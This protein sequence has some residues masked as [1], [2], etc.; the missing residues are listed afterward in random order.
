MHALEQPYLDLLRDVLDNGTVKSD[1]T[2]TGTISSF[3]RQ[4]RFDLSRGFPLL[5][6]K[7]MHTKSIIGELLW[8]LR[9]ETNVQSLQEDGIRIWNEWAD[10]TGELGPVYGKQ[11]RRWEGKNGVVVDQ[12]A[13]LVDDLKNNPNS[14]RMLVSAW[15]VAE[16][17]EAALPPC[18]MLF[19]CYVAN[20][21]LSCQLYQRSCDLF[22]GVPFNIA[23]YSLLTH[24]LALECGLEVGEFIW[25]GGDCH[26]YQ[27]HVAQVQLQL[28]RTPFAPPQLVI[29]RKA[30]DLYSYKIEDF[31]I[32]DYQCHERI[33]ASVAV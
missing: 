16:I 6:T 11:W 23:S 1:R 31:E 2:G 14:R 3:A 25:T 19:Q 12:I 26:I 9:G 7:K 18:H 13:N 15:N 29:K 17:S 20:G 28:S 30:A 27:N 24:L 8:F 21:K 22:L 10:A 4:M 33:A 5:T 32:V